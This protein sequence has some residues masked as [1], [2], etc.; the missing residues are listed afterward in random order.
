MSKTKPDENR[1]RL[2]AENRKARHN[3][4]IEDTYEAGIALVGSEVKALRGGRANITDA[5]ADTRNGE[6]FLVNAYIPEYEQANRNKHEE[7]RPRKLLLHRREVDRMIGA[8]Q[9]EGYTLVPLSIYFNE[10]GRAKVSLALA[11]GKQMHDKRQSD[12]DRDWAR[13]KGRLLRDRG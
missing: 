6:V 3:Y 11:K 8:V 4:F 10:R 7:R 13:E 9:R 12:K 1:Y 2:A 5:Y